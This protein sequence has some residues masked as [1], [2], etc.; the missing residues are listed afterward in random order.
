MG[1]SAPDSL[2]S[3]SSPPFRLR[4]R[5]G[6]S[7]AGAPASLRSPSGRRSHSPASLYSAGNFIMFF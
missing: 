2:F 3:Y 4:C 1:L 7:A 6:R 5:F